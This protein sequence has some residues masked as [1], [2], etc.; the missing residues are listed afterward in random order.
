MRVSHAR[1][2]GARAL[3]VLVL[4]GMLTLP[5]VASGAVAVPSTIDATGRTEVT[6]PLQR[7]IAAVPDGTTVVLR[8]GGTYRIDGTLAWRD[9][10]G[11]TIDGNGATLIAGSH[12]GPN[13]A[14]IRLLDGARWT[15][16]NLRIRGSYPGGRPFDP[17]FQWQHG[18]D[19][20][21]VNG[22]VIDHVAITNV[23]GDA[24]YVGLSTTRQ[25]WSQD[26]LISDSTGVR[27]GRMSVSITA[28]RHVTVDGGFWSEPALSTFDL[29][30]N[31]PSGGADDVLITHTTIG[32][33][34][35]GSALMVPSALLVAGYSPVSNVTFRDNRLSGSPLVVRVFQQ[36]SI[37]TRNLVVQDNLSTVPLAGLGPAAIVLHK[38]DGV[39]VT[40][41]L[42]P[43]SRGLA[44][45]A[46]EDC[47]MVNVSGSH[48]TLPPAGGRRRLRYV[49]ALLALLVLAGFIT[50]VLRRRRRDTQRP[51]V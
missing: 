37:R 1:A 45:V 29:E 19:L 33:R 51:G 8:H 15:I 7:F 35:Q 47:T 24:V 36:G 2:L 21:G 27:T 25:R 49:V 22:V 46:T 34:E 38:T 41:N 5:D 32:T 11:I 20:R 10:T 50:V 26:V 4:A 31:G 13:R 17:R 9:R 30:P 14:E 43:L 16:R 44:L 12:G 39:T 23:F 40:G 48:V 3:V 6:A 42:Q 18:I 28:G